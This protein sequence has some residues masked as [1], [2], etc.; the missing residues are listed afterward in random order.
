MARGSKPGERRGGRQKGVK[1]ATTTDIK[2]VASLHGKE[3]IDKLVNLMKGADSEQVQVAAAR[4][5]LD[6]AY[7][8]APQAIVGSEDGPPIKTILEVLWAGTSA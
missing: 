7:G 6:R 5:I 8:K 1:N 4:E 2:A 3:A